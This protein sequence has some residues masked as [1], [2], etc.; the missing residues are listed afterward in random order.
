MW[1]VLHQY[2]QSHLARIALP[3]GGIGTGTISLGGRGELRDW[4]I[5]NHPAKGFNPGGCFFAINIQQPGSEPITRALE[6]QIDPADYEGSSGCAISNHGL[7]RFRNCIFEAAYPFGQVQL[8]DPEIPVEVK[9]QAFNPLIPTD[10]DSSGIPLAVFRFVLKNLTKQTLNTAVCAS[11]ANF[12]GDIPAPPN[13]STTKQNFFRKEDTFQGIMMTPGNIDS[14]AEGYGT[15]ALVTT[16]HDGIS[17]QTAWKNR[18][19]GS[20][21]LFFW[22]DFNQDGALEEQETLPEMKSPI[23]SLS[24]KLELPPLGSETITFFICWHFPNRYTWTPSPSE[25]CCTKSP[26]EKDWIGNYYT[27]QYQDAW[28]V[29]VKVRPQLEKLEEQTL[30]FVSTFC[31]SSLPAEVKEAALFNLST[32]RS[33]TCFRTP[34]GRFFGWEGCNNQKGCCHGSC[35]HVWNYEQ[36][37]P[38]L[39]G[40]LA[41]SMR[42]TEFGLA[43]REDG[44]MSFR[45]NLPLERAQDFAHAAADGQM[46]CLMKLYRDWQLS[47]DDDL[48]RALW[49]FAKKALS[50]AWISG[51]WDSDQ[52]GVMEG[53]QHNTMDVEYFGPNPQIEGW[54]LGALRAT[55]EMATYLGDKEF[56]EK[57]KL[58]F[59][60]GRDWT[61]KHLFNG[62]YY[63]HQVMPPMDASQIAP[64]LILGMGARD[65]SHPDYQLGS[66]CQVDQLIGQTMANVCG[67][68]NLL[69]PENTHK[70]LQ[71]ILKYNRRLTFRDHFNCLRSYAL[72]DESGLLV[73]S[74]PKGRPENPFPYFTE[75]WTGLEYAAAVELIYEGLI[76]EGIR[77]IHDTRQRYDGFRRNPFDEAECGHHYARAMASWA[78]ILA[79]T[80]FHYSGLS[81][82]MTI[83]PFEGQYFW[84]NGY[85]WGQY[86]ISQ[87]ED[88]YQIKLVVLMGKLELEFIHLSGVGE[89]KLENTFHAPKDGDTRVFYLRKPLP[90]F[91]N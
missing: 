24:V 44:C 58:L 33:Q 84:S 71:S 52:D 62:E 16:A 47:G 54:Y 10:P 3:I 75:V 45:V 13:E 85:A 80:G 60:S 53:C 41:R 46:G 86:E 22:D 66:G 26:Q 83:S 32:L 6:G 48:L 9:L 57:C 79:L 65:L 68:G 38:Y 67:L 89:I 91:M 8:T 78:A 35:T 19:W 72:G 43:I 31:K 87:S 2:D 77:C 18:G 69:D 14:K 76:E 73:A 59:T 50:F 27:T 37:T 42:E 63:E 49:P 12:I 23:G 20:A 74:Y 61:D 36:A 82:R 17:Y 11:L 90:R 25:G 15:L 64:S 34:D 1:P 4:E 5:M 56:A 40:E 21:L 7:P 39:F 70:T 29:A 30:Q 51:G 28:D 88:E 55:E 81:K